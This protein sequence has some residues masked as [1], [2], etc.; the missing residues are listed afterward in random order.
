[1]FAKIWCTDFILAHEIKEVCFLSWKQV[2][3]ERSELT[4]CSCH[5]RFVGY[6]CIGRNFEFSSRRRGIVSV[7]K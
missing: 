7:Q 2:I 5:L 1:M 3:G 6:I 4:L